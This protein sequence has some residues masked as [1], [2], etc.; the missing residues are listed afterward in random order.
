MAFGI[1][2]PSHGPQH[3]G[4]TSLLDTS[5]VDEAPSVAELERGTG[6]HAETVLSPQPSKD[7]ND[8]LRWPLWQRDLMFL[9]HIYCTILCV[10]GIGPMLAAS[11]AVPCP[12][13]QRELYGRD[14]LDGI[15]PLCCRRSEPVSLGTIWGGAATSYNSLLGARIVQGF[16]MFAVIGDIY[17]VHERGTRVAAL[18]IAI[19]GIANLPAL[20][21]GLIN[22]STRPLLSATKKPRV[23]ISHPQRYVVRK[24][25]QHSPLPP[26]VDSLANPRVKET[27]EKASKSGQA[28]CEAIENADTICAV[29]APNHPTRKPFLH[30]LA[31]FS[32]VHSQMP[33]WEMILKPFLILTHPA[34]VFVVAQIFTAPPYSLEAVDIGYMSAG[35]VIGG[36]LGSIV[37]GLVSDPVARALA[38]RN[39]G[40]YEPEFRLVLIIPMLIASAL[41]WFLFGNLVVAGTSPSV[42]AVVWAITTISRQFGMTTIGAYIL[43]GISKHLVRGV[44]HR[45][46]VEELCVLWAFVWCQQL[47][48]SVGPGEGL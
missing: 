29:P 13:L 38:R 14:P 33:L 23:P 28:Q 4:G 35:P 5:G 18:T 21:S 20:L 2:S 26:Q 9:M 6:K 30:R 25:P 45:D 24:T 27:G 3:V 19:S 7:P 36:T 31:P 1:L 11:A 34:V 39:R 41:G 42:I 40:V 44:Y 46:G 16:V 8:P 32:G 15:Q 17:Y 12:E 47:G 43:D 22:R 10:G 48:R 37:C